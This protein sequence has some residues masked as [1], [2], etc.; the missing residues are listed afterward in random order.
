MIIKLDIYLTVVPDFFIGFL[1]NIY[2]QDFIDSP[3][4]NLY[5]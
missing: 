1:K 2:K 4:Q 5:S 3:N